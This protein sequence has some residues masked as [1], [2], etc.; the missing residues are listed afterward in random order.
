M[1]LSSPGTA[2]LE[3]KL[4]GGSQTRNVALWHA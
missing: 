1:A 2:A 3:K 4:A